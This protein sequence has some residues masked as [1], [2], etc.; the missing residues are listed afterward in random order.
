MTSRYSLVRDENESHEPR[1]ADTFSD[2]DTSSTADEKVAQLLK[3]Q[4]WK[5]LRSLGITILALAIFAIVALAPWA[6]LQDKPNKRSSP[7]PDL[8]TET[9][10]F[11]NYSDYSA[12]PTI[13]NNVMWMD[14]LGTGMGFVSIK[15]PKRYG[16]LDGV[17]NP[18]MP[19]DVQNYGVSM[20]HQLH[21]LMMIRTLYWQAL[22][23]DRN[24]KMDENDDLEEEMGH[25]NHCF[26]YI[27][28]GIMCAGD[29][30]I[31]SAADPR[32][33]EGPHISGIGMRHEC[34]SWSASRKWMDENLPSR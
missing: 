9:V 6:A 30:S 1:D 23:G 33:G 5:R 32:D 11:G 31:E 15:D 8:P 25:V 4:N 18:H 14:L 28:Q 17:S 3:A 29:M 27:R 10:I 13:E 19:P 34:K 20:Y 22:R 24:L 21:C 2:I 16:L 26:D 7:V 12:A